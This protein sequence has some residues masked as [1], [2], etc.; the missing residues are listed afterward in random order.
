YDRLDKA[1]IRRGRFDYH[2]KIDRPD[3]KAAE[4][5]VESAMLRNV[6]ADEPPSFNRIVTIN[7]T[8]NA[9]LGIAFALSFTPLLW[10][11]ITDTPFIIPSVGGITPFF[12]AVTAIFVAMG[13]RIL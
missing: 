1:A 11:L 9:L 8:L 13:K 5:I 4:K 10:A 12:I 7:K 6:P 3:K 2:I